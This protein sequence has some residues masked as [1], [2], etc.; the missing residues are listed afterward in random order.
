[1]CCVAQLLFVSICP[2]TISEERQDQEIDA[3]FEA[4]IRAGV[5]NDASKAGEF[6]AETEIDARVAA[7][8]ANLESEAAQRQARAWAE[9][10]M[11]AYESENQRKFKKIGACV[12]A[13]SSIVMVASVV[14]QGDYMKLPLMTAMAGVMTGVIIYNSY[15]VCCPPQSQE[16]SPLLGPSNV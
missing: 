6:V 16:V 13:L 3:R 15:E 5:I 12:F 4:A 9:L 14:L 8:R 2:R 1:M 11:P 10:G 7:I